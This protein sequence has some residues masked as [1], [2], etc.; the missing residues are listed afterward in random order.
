MPRVGCRS[1]TSVAIFNVSIGVGAGILYAEVAPV[2]AR[3]T[4]WRI[5]RRRP[6][7]CSPSRARSPGA[8]LSEAVEFNFRACLDVSGGPN[9]GSAA[10]LSEI[11]Y[12]VPS[13]QYLGATDEW[14][15]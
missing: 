10:L 11:P 13:A 6:F 5:P 14:D 15:L 4:H 8:Y 7:V 3:Q 12:L 2:L 9:W 1:I